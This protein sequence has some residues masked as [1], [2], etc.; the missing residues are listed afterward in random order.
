MSRNDFNDSFIKY[1]VAI[2][3]KAPKYKGSLYDAILQANKNLTPITIRN[4]NHI[5]ISS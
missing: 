1:F 3:I 5:M 2:S 4:I